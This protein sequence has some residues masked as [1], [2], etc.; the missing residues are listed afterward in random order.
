MWR[1]KMADFFNEIIQ[2]DDSNDEFEGFSA[3]E[4]ENEKGNDCEGE[5]RIDD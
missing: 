3:D 1:D 4:D 5:I 2:D